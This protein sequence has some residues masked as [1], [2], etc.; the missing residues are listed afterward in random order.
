METRGEPSVELDDHERTRLDRVAAARPRGGVDRRRRGVGRAEAGERRAARAR[1]RRGARPPG[2]GGWSTRRARSRAATSRPG[3]RVVELLT[4]STSKGDAVERL[5]RDYGAR[6]RASS[7]TTAPTRRCSPASARDDFGIRVGPGTTAAAIPPAR[8]TAGRSSGWRLA[9]RLRRGHRRPRPLLRTLTARTH[10]TPGSVC[11][12]RP[13]AASGAD[14][15]GIV[16]RQNRVGCSG[17]TTAPRR[18]TARS[19]P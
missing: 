16:G 5:R 7:V 6:R 1:G 9:H 17:R 3:T 2:H 14:R 10:P 8:S 11:S 4:R 15:S 12:I 18:S 13:V 19:G